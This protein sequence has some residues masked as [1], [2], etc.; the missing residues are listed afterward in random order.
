VTTL[1]KSIKS[2]AKALLEMN[3]VAVE[4]GA[5]NVNE[6]NRSIQNN[7]F[8]LSLA[9]S[10][11]SGA[12]AFDEDP[13]LPHNLKTKNASASTDKIETVR[14]ENKQKQNTMSLALQLKRAIESAVLLVHPEWAKT[15]MV[16][17][18]VQAFSDFLVYA[19]DSNSVL[20]HW[21]I[22]VFD[23][24]SGF[25]DIYRGRHYGKIYPPTKRTTNTRRARNNDRG[26][27]GARWR[28]KECD[29]GA[30]RGNTLTLR[31]VDSH[32]QPLLPELTKMRDE[33]R[34]DVDSQR[35]LVERPTLEDILTTL[36]KWNVLH[37]VTDGRA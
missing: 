3:L 23:E 37:V 8:Y 21:A 24:A 10:Y 14:L 6:Q 1:R 4:A 31:Y 36:D 30:K 20:G 26:T 12:G 7:C 35:G 32:Y 29:D 19:L 25:V 17:E 5:V 33:G 13:T 9:A 22:A 18:E 27:A 11:L 34:R 15:G 16:G 28:Y 2:Q